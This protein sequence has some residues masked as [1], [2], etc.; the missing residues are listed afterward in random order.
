[1]RCRFGRVP[2]DTLGAVR[3]RVLEA[4]GEQTPTV[5]GAE[6]GHSV[7][8]L[9]FVARL[10][11]VRIRGVKAGGLSSRPPSLR[12]NHNE[13]P[14]PRTTVIIMSGCVSLRHSLFPAIMG[15]LNKPRTKL[16]LEEVN[17]RGFKSR[18]GAFSTKRFVVSTQGEARLFWI[19]EEEQLTLLAK[20]LNARTAGEHSSVR[21]RIVICLADMD[22]PTG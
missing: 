21:F 9:S 14:T 13:S 7:P 8:V 10:R 18:R 12:L 1:M 17:V 4:L 5:V 15:V 3:E 6:R 11:T 19:T 20:P 22:R 16:V 2:A